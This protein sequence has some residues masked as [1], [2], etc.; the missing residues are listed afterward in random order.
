MILKNLFIL[1]LLAVAAILVS[2]RAAEMQPTVSECPA[3]VVQAL[4]AVGN[5]AAGWPEMSAC[6]GFNRVAATFSQSGGD[7]I[8]QAFRSNRFENVANH[9][10]C[11]AQ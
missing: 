6:Y 5:G 4:E 11:T 8:Q 3:L 10:D 7:C 9:R 2:P 1:I